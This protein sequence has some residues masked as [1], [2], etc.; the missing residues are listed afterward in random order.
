MECD[1][2][3]CI[4]SLDTQTNIVAIPHGIATDNDFI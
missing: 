2:M 4:L 3:Q 1:G